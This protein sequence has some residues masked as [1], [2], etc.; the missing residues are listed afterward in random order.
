MLSGYNSPTG[1]TFS[2]KADTIGFNLDATM[3][4]STS[5][6]IRAVLTVVMLL[7]TISCT[8]LFFY[9]A[10][11]HAGVPSDLGYNYKDVWI[12]TRDHILLHG[13]LIQPEGELKGS[14][15]FLHGN[16]ENIST[17]IRSV[18]WMIM[19]GYQVLALDYRGFGR[20]QGE[21]DIPEVFDDLHAGVEWIR[22][23]LDTDKPVYVFGQSLGASL[24]IK[25]F[26]LYSAS[27]SDFSGLIVEAAFSRYGAIAR[28]VASGSWLT[29][30]FQY[31]IQWIYSFTKGGLYD[32][33]DV[34]GGLSPLPLLIIHSQDDGIIPVSHG[35]ELF[36]AARDPKQF[37][38]AKGA[39]IHAIRDPQ[40]RRQILSFMERNSRGRQKFTV[41]PGTARFPVLDRSS[42][43]A[44]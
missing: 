10:R 3:A 41:N 21:P 15:Y 39:H 31:P 6:K 37:L 20:S 35:R 12:N 33:V 2:R 8:G 11:Q 22:D 13:W 28:H 44:Y 29:W 25:Y 30:I 18:L 40:I 19:Q 16:A 24:A 5:I 26:D 32:P 34:V 23:N 27:R 1:I 17:H 14:V 7:C 38:A 9:P 43:I 42:K 36:S 4:C